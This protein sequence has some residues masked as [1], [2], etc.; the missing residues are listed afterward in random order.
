M[1]R[2]GEAKESPFTEADLRLIAIGSADVSSAP[3]ASNPR[4]LTEKRGKPH[5]RLWVSVAVGLIAI[6]SIGSVVGARAVA[7]TDAER[8]GQSFTASAK[9]I[10][11]L[12]QKSLEHE[13]D[14]AFGASAFLVSN[15][16]VSQ[17][18]FE[19]WASAIQAFARY[20][21]V[22]AVAELVRV[23]GSQLASFSAREIADPPGL[24]ASDGTLGITPAGIRPFY[25]LEA[26]AA[27]R[28]ATA[29][30][31][32]G[33]DY[34][35]T[36]LGPELRRARNSGKDTYLPFGSG[37]S[38]DLAIGTP[39]YRGGVVPPTLKA[40]QDAFMGWTGTQIRPSVLLSSA[41]ADHTATA[42][43]FHFDG[44][45]SNVSFNA[46][47]APK[48]ARAMSIR[49]SNG[50]T[51][52]VSA[53]VSGSAVFANR[54]SVF[55]LLVGLTLSLLLGFLIFVL[56]T[57]RSRAVVMVNNRTD[58]LN[59]LAFHDPLT[60]L[61]NRALILD[62]LGQMMSRAKR[63]GISVAAIFLDID[64]FKEVNDTLGH[65]AG[66]ELLVEVSS[67]LTQALREGD[68]VGR[69][70]GDEFV[71]LV[72]GNSLAT[73][74]S[75]VAERILTALRAPFQIKASTTPLAITASAGIATGIREK[76]EDLLRDADIALYRAKVEG[77]D[78]AAVFSSLMHEAVEI[79]RNLE[80]DLRR[81]AVE[82]QFFVLYQPTLRLDTGGITGVEALLRWR[83][84]TRGVVGPD[85]FIPLLESSGLI[86]EVG[87]WV[88]EVAC[89]QG[90]QWASEGHSLTMAVNI[91]SVQL[92]DDAIVDT[93][94][95]ALLASGFDPAYLILELTE[96][97]LMHDV[98]TTANKLKSLKS[99]GIRVAIDDFGTGYS[100]LSY[101]R[102]FPIDI[103][104]IDQ[105]FV[106][107]IAE[108]PESAA[109]VH[110]L[111]QLGKLLGLT[112]VAEG[113]ETDEQWARLEAE[114][115]DYGQGFL[116]SRPVEAK[117]I[118]QQL[119]AT[120]MR[121][122]TVA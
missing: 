52:T 109:I 76:P 84:P 113:I 116:F 98:Q 115:V 18:G 53:A 68:S 41:L 39:I 70:G 64:E 117:A 32:A 31:P 10:A 65:S 49:L 83:H 108:T 104:K 90:A 103:L 28:S 42:V 38:L 50:W 56:A 33:I 37:K 105:S 25:C 121:M 9:D 77:R 85:E 118:V 88:L 114:G 46:G 82:G 97:T 26:V 30:T 111:V 11:L 75:V 71:V 40:R 119:G 16:H 102:Q 20:P 22:L 24:L 59:H 58:Q 99:T 19:N 35:Q 36:S 34:C 120:V 4:G 122:L 6:G 60:G 101:L 1:K 67:R 69:F 51:V 93:V 86:K 57:S 47:S 106:M 29:V 74:A 27:V 21:E 63:E 14:L 13:Q 44:N 79:H 81:A 78:R 3:E 72:D 5:G 23:P 112:T 45:G 87:S 91:S 17:A 96:T 110:T 48:D 92:D 15:Q 73:G 62:R 107:G 12:L 66:D 80:L 2:P 43:A 95:H 89:R 100:S 54:N 94:K 55:V 7:H 61:P 8:S